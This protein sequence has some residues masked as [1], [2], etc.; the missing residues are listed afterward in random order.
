MSE[1][2]RFFKLRNSSGNIIGRMIMDR[3]GNSNVWE[4]MDNK[5]QASSF[6]PLTLTH[7]L[8]TSN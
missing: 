2:F 7:S 8:F 1:G 5:V 4:N 6:P 3:H